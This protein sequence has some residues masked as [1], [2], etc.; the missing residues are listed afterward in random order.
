M[1]WDG[2]TFA[3]AASTL[4]G[5]M[6][7]MPGGLGVT[8]VGMTA[9]L[10]TLGGPSMHPAVATATTML[11][12]IATL[13]FAVAIGLLALALHRARRPRVALPRAGEGAAPPNR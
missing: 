7:M 4:A 6:A 13:W 5:A 10:Q 3:Y 8:E 9:L 1:S 12:R 11:V 2:A